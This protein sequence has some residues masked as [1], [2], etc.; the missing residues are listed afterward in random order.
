MS[1]SKPNS[2]KICVVFCCVAVFHKGWVGL[3]RVGYD[4]FFS[5]H[6]YLMMLA[7]TGMKFHGNSKDHKTQLIQ[8]IHEHVKSVLF[9]FPILIIN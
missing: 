2:A 6:I 4:A 9:F 3:R 1:K 7:D 8:L 5:S